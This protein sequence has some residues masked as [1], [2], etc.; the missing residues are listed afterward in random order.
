MVC[1]ALGLLGIGDLRISFDLSN[2]LF[3]LFSEISI[4]LGL[5]SSENA[6]R[7]SRSIALG[8]LWLLAE[9]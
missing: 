9:L 1:I 8:P 7:T 4:S 5:S 6:S 3:G 2:G